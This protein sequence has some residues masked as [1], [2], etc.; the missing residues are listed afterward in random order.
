MWRDYNS[1]MLRAVFTT[2]EFAEEYSRSVDGYG[3]DP[4]VLARYE[5]DLATTLELKLWHGVE[6]QKDCVASIRERLPLIEEDNRSAVETTATRPEDQLVRLAERFHLVARQLRERR[7]GSP[8][9]IIENEY[10]VQ[11][12]LHALLKVFYDD[13]RSEEWTPSYVGGAARMTFY[14]LRSRRLW[15]PR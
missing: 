1:H 11:Y 15:R 12:L 2:H 4:K 10:D 13:I 8:P 6:S 3:V 14:Y 5:N 9:L 7:T